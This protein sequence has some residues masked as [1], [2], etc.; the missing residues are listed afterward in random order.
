MKWPLKPTRALLPRPTVLPPRPVIFYADG[1]IASNRSGVGSFGTLDGGQILTLA[2]RTLKPMTNNEAEYHGLLLLFDLASAAG[3][4]ANPIEVRMDS[5]IVVYQ[6]RGRFSV[7]SPSLKALHRE[8]CARLTA[9]A[10]L[11]FQPIPREQ[12]RLADALAADAAQGRLWS[13]EPR[14]PENP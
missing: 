4:Q 13:F 6:M 7:H 10:A 9:F 2:N 8:A 5:E 12:N 11:R 14:K 3:L 1:A